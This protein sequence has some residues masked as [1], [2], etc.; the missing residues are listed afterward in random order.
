MKKI[1]SIVG[2]SLVLLVGQ[3][4]V[5]FKTIVPQQPVIAGESFQVQYIIEE[6]EKT[7]S[8]KPPPFKNFR[9]V[10]GP[11]IYLGSV[12]TLSGAKPLQNT[13]Y[14]LE[15]TRPGQFIIP[16]ATLTINGKLIRSNDALLIVISK[17]Q[18]IKRLSKDN[19]MDA[20]DYLLRPGENAYEKIKQNLFVKVMVDKRNCFVG[21][22]IVATFKLYSRVESKSDIVKNPGFYGFTVYDMINLSDKQ[23]TTENF[24]G[25]KF[26]VHTIRKAQLYP[27]QAGTFTVDAMEVKNKVEFSRSVFNK[28]TEQE[29]IEG[30]LG[31]TNDDSPAEGTE[32]FET[33]LRT[34]PITVH[35]KPIPE[36]NKPT[37]FTGATGSFTITTFFEK[38]KL[39]KNEEGFFRIAISGKGNFIQLS[40]PTVQWPAG[41]EGF[42]PQIKDVFDKARAPLAGSRIFSYPFVASKPGIYTIP[43]IRFSFFSTDS[44]GYRTVVAPAVAININPGDRIVNTFLKDYPVKNGNGKNS[45]YWLAGIGFVLLSTII[46]SRV[47]IMRKSR[48]PDPSVNPVKPII[49]VDEIIT[50]VYSMLSDST[51]FYAALQKAIWYFFNQHFDLSGT[52]MNKLVLFSKLSN[53]GITAEKVRELQHIL[54]ECEVGIFTHVTPGKSREKLLQKAR[55]IMEEM[56]NSWK[57]LL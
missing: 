56:N 9:F 15:A 49:L 38:D 16:G 30:V 36:K 3:G 52:E 42:D 40:A 43:A 21:E 12:S 46:L 13:V 23:V 18:A 14:T 24:N 17:E 27:L 29:I 34:E 20:S 35:V 1:V 25:K 47:L 54:E 51:R 2:F 55:Q 31:N 8:V 5:N 32:I 26:D 53:S 45:N 11:N 7:M 4:Q 44:G 57:N 37:V 48:R 28:K 10:A 50:P 19:G 6:G 41:L 33:D 22:P 39:K